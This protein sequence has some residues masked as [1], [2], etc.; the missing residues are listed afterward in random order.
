MDVPAH[1]DGRVGVPLVALRKARGGVGAH[2]RGDHVAVSVGIHHAGHV[3]DQA[4]LPVIGGVGSDGDVL[5]Q[6][7]ADVVVQE[8]LVGD[9]AGGQAVLGV[10]G[11]LGGEHGHGV[12]VVLLRE[13]AVVGQ[14]ALDGPVLRV[15]LAR[16]S[17]VGVGDVE[18]VD[19][20]AGEAAALVGAEVGADG[21][22]EGEALDPGSLQLDVGRV[23]GAEAG[24][25]TDPAVG[26]L[27]DVAAGR[28]PHVVERHARADEPGAVGSLR[29]QDR[30]E[31]EDAVEAQLV[32][33]GGVV[34]G[35]GGEADL[36]PVGDVLVEAAAQGDTVVVLRRDHGL[37]LI[38]GHAEAVA[39][40][41]GAAHH[42]EF[43]VAHHAGAVEEVLPVGVEGFVLEAHLVGELAGG[44]AQRDVV[45]G[46]H[47]RVFDG[48]LEADV[49]VEAHLRSLAGHAL[50]RRDEDDAV[51]AAGAVD[52]GGGGILEDV[53]ALDVARGDVGEGPHERHAVQH[54]ER[55]VGGGQGAVAADADFHARARTGR[56][57]GHLHAGHAAVQ[58]AGEV[59]GGDFA[60]ALA[61]H[62]GDGAGHI[63]LAGRT[64]ADDHDGIQ[65]LGV[66]GHDDIDPRAPL[67]GYALGRISHARDFEGRGRADLEGIGPVDTGDGADRG[68]QD[69]HGSSDDGLATR[70]RDRAADGD[71]LREGEERGRQGQGCDCE[72]FL[73]VKLHS[74]LKLG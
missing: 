10:G 24:V 29:I 57:L 26:V 38:I 40:L 19:A 62:R 32:A 37:V 47:H 55:V 54:D 65:G 45:R 73:E 36:E 41:H 22:L 30:G 64:V 34:V 59:A 39:A 27:L 43:V 71:V 63:R 60:E 20:L 18:A 2:G 58:R 4:G 13:G 67:H 8:L 74:V 69:H 33:V 50:V 9:V 15:V 46:V 70:V 21:L 31:L 23:V 28:D 3:G 6:G 49:V 25:V 44:L 14:Q 1:G 72:R 53:H 66:I 35:V 42:A 56:G 52:G 17:A 7:L 68:V 61:A 51:G 12:E 48:V 5:G 16:G 11:L